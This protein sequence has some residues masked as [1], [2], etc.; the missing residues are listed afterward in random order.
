MLSTKG[1]AQITFLF[2]LY[3]LVEDETYPIEAFQTFF[4]LR[5]SSSYAKVKEGDVYNK[6]Q[7]AS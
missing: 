4:A 2:Y 1:G 3:V 6:T 5:T 7:G